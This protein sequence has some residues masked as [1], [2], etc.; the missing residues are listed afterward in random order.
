M[1][2]LLTTVALLAVLSTSAMAKERII[3]GH[4]HEELNQC[5]VAGSNEV[6]VNTTEIRGYEWACRIVKGTFTP[7]R[8]SLQARCSEAG[9]YET[10]TI[11]LS[12]VVI[13]LGNKGLTI[14]GDKPLNYGE[15]DKRWRMTLPN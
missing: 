5:G 2:Y 9:G 15:A 4:W 8:W 11:P 1:K 10:H 7:T 3:D 13:A 14:T 6:E 12:K